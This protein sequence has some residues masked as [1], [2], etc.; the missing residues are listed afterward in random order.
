MLEWKG[1]IG[2]LSVDDFR[3]EQLCLEYGIT[4]G[5]MKYE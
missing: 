5:R 4:N 3:A 2:N 1:T